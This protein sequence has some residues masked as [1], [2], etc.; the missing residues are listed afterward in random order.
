MKQ[1]CSVEWSWSWLWSTEDCA[2]SLMIHGASYYGTN[3]SPLTIARSKRSWTF[4]KFNG[5]A[6]PWSRTVVTETETE[7]IAV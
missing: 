2:Q 4:Q 6:N 5:R 1:S 7:Y 3:L